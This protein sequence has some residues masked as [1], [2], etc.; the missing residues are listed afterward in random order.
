MFCGPKAPKNAQTSMSKLSAIS[1]CHTVLFGFSLP[2][3]P[4]FVEFVTRLAVC[5][6][7]LTHRL[8]VQVGQRN[9]LG[10]EEGK[11]M[12]SL[13]QSLALHYQGVPS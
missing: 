2:C 8:H 10:V 3:P 4:P 6:W 13:M 12:F 11:Q 1:L 5:P 7:L 9:E